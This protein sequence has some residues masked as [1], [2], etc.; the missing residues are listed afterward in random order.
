MFHKSDPFNP[1]KIKGTQLRKESWK[2]LEERKRALWL[3]GTQR[4]QAPSR[5]QVAPHGR[6]CVSLRWIWWKK[7]GKSLLG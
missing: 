7:L 2:N 4:E 3:G 1:Y 6:T 5:R